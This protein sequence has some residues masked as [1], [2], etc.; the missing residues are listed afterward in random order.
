M[1]HLHE[2]LKKP[3]LLWSKKVEHPLPMKILAI[4]TAATIRSPKTSARLEPSPLVFL[5]AT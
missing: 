3:R 4:T 2:M 5:M 1:Q